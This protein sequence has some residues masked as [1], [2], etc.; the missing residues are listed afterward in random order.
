MQPDEVKQ[1]LEST[2]EGCDVDVD[3]NGS[4]FN[5]VIVS[6]VFEDLRPLKRQQMVYAALSS[7][8]A[9]GTIHAVN[10]KTFTRAEFDQQA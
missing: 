1:L 8:I 2:I 6:G 9:D 10:M 3:I 7:K 4:H 5:L